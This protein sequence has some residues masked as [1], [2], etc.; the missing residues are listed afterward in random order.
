MRKRSPWTRYGDGHA[1][2]FD[3]AGTDYFVIVTD[4]YLNTR[5]RM[6]ADRPVDRKTLIEDIDDEIEAIAAAKLA[7][8]EATQPMGRRAAQIV[9][10]AGDAAS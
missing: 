1:A 8:G 10:D 6:P 4:A 3:A 7:R 9:I 2:D 5:Y